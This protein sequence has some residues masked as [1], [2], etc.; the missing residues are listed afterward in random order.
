MHIAM[1]IEQFKTRHFEKFPHQF[2]GVAIDEIIDFRDIEACMGNADHTEGRV[3]AFLGGQLPYDA[4]TD[5]YQDINAVRRRISIPKIEVLL[6]RGATVSI[7]RIDRQLAQAKS[8]C[9]E[10]QSFTGELVTSNCY[11]AVSGS[12][13]FGVHWDT[14]DVFAV[15][16]CG[17]KRWTIYEPTF[18]LPIDGQST[19]HAHKARLSNPFLDI[20][21][22]AGDVL[23]I[24]RGWWHEAVPIAGYPTI[25]FAAG[26]HTSTVSDYLAWLSSDIA[27]RELDFRRSI[28]TETRQIDRFERSLKR[29]LCLAM[30]EGNLNTYR[31]MQS[32]CVRER[33]SA[34]SESFQTI[35]G[36]VAKCDI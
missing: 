17:R 28:S 33:S 4:F 23:Y 34:L 12:G 20:V 10:L 18:T 6:Q 30:A 29:F 9:Q 25:H 3:K 26:L 7:N 15:Q 35:Y 2:K 32:H 5:S 16:V 14:H 31:T 1:P 19:I 8:I 24:P 27:K 11:A 13:S 36:G 21:L 22:E